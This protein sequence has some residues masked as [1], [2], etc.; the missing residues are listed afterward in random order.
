LVLFLLF[1]AGTQQAAELRGLLILGHVVRSLQLCG[2]ER[3]FWLH[4]P[5]D[6]RQQLESAYHRP[7]TNP[8][9]PMYTEIEGEFSEQ[10]AS[11]F[12]VD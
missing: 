4:I 8:Y 10:A 12:A 7:A 1:F 2:E 9:E 3:V 5:A 11:G 6:Q